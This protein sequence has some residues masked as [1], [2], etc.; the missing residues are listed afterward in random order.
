VIRLL[1][2]LAVIAA[3]VLAARH[4]GVFQH[5]TL[6]NMAKLKDWIAGYGVLGPVIYILLWIAACLFFLPGLPVA[7]LGGV[8]FGPLWGTVYSSLGS[9]VG[10]TRAFLLARYVARGMVEGWVVGNAQFKKIDEGVE[11]QGWRIL[12]V[13]RLVPAFPFNLQNFA[14]GL[15]RIS[16]P[17]YVAVSWSCML[18]GTIAFSF[19]GGSLTGGDMKKTF[20]MLGVAAVFFVFVSLIPGWIKKRQGGDTA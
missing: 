1:A 20:M 18:P 19:A 2:V 17:V 15:T 10:A 14:Y 13:T 8:A 12:M 6:E 9:T 3:V 7:L 4:F 11:R 16:L 5:L